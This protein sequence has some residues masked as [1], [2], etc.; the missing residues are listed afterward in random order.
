MMTCQERNTINACCVDVSVRTQIML[1]A[2]K[3]K[4][5]NVKF[6]C[7]VFTCTGSSEHHLQVRLSLVSQDEQQKRSVPLLLNA[8]SVQSPTQ[9]H[10]H[11]ENDLCGVYVLL[12]VFQCSDL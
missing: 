3:Q 8:A 12:N 2:S 9:T 4:C 1:Y 7:H 11:S 6:L 5:Y 10:K